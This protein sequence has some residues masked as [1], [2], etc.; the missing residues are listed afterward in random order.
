MSRPVFAVFSIRKGN[1][2]TSAG[3]AVKNRDGSLNVTL[4]VLPLDGQLHIRASID[5]DQPPEVFLQL[6]ENGH[7]RLMIERGSAEAEK[8]QDVFHATT[9]TLRELRALALTVATNH[10]AVVADFWIRGDW[11]TPTHPP[12]ATP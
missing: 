10:K 9:Y 1:V 6:T 7:A 3:R 2:W 4:D 12:G 8:L 5:A 11:S